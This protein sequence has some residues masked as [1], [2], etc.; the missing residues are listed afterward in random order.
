[1]ETQKIPS[2]DDNKIQFVPA[3]PQIGAGLGHKSQA[4]DLQHKFQ[5]K[6]QGDYPGYLIEYVGV[7][8]IGSVLSEVLVILVTSSNGIDDDAEGQE[9]VEP[10]RKVG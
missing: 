2:A 1:M 3:I 6:D 10:S 8:L 4:D 9:M 7:L 5:N